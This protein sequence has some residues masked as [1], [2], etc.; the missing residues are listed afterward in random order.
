MSDIEKAAGLIRAKL[1][2]FAPK[3]AVI[4]GSGLGAVA[5]LIEEQAR[6]PYTDLPG[7]PRPAVA[8]HEGLMRLGT[9]GGVPVIFLKGRVH[10]YEGG[11]FAPLRNMIRTLKKLGVE[12]LFITNAAGSLMREYGPG[13]V[14]AIRDHI[15]LTGTNPLMG[16]NDDEW[17]PRFPPME[18]AWD[19]DL[20]ARLLAAAKKAGVDLGTGVYC[21]FLGPTFETP[22]EIG[23]AKA[24]GADLV[25]MSTVTDNI[26]ARHCGLKCVGVSAVTNLAAGM[27]E[28]ALSHE[29]TL[30]GAKLAEQKMAQIVKGFIL[31]EAA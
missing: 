16:P 27:G 19:A 26:I 12:N 1:P 13:S 24:I 14:V 25:G 28:E 10:L 18:N 15:N 4:L 5:D 31:G 20:R 21:Q 22:A 7:F 30:D 9:V 29:Q 23:M 3:L 8:G 2:G 6:T 17:G 11:D